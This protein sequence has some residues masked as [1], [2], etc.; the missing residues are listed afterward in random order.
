VASRPN[1]KI[2][3][4]SAVSEISAHYITVLTLRVKG[5]TGPAVSSCIRDA[6]ASGSGQSVGKHRAVNGADLYWRWP[7]SEQTPTEKWNNLVELFYVRIT[8]KF[9]R[10][11]VDPINILI[12]SSCA[13]SRGTK[14]RITALCKYIWNRLWSLIISIRG[15]WRQSEQ[16]ILNKLIIP[17]N[18]PSSISIVLMPAVSTPLSSLHVTSVSKNYSRVYYSN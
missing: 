6:D 10:A 16:C 11:C 5:C 3:P 14:S 9:R 17:I 8:V 13:G 18:N 12:L 7:C 2:C 1:S 15:Q 4:R